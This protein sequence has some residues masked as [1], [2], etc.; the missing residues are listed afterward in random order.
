MY[1]Y[2]S[3][4]TRYGLWEGL[5]IKELD[6]KSTP[7]LDTFLAAVSGRP[8]GSSLRLKVVTLNKQTDVITLRPD[9]EYW[10]TVDLRK[11]STGWDRRLVD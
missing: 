11:Q 1:R 10:P 3:P 8:R 7:D 9:P 6:G 4:A 5:R 2:G